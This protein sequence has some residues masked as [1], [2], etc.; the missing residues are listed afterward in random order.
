V[1]ERRVRAEK[2]RKKRRSPLREEKK[3][4]PI[5]FSRVNEGKKKGEGEVCEEREAPFPRL[6]SFEGEGRKK[7]VS[8]TLILCPEERKK[9]GKGESTCCPGGER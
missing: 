6:R 8:P 5:S 7:K 9:R 4:T 3:K 1:R 2:N